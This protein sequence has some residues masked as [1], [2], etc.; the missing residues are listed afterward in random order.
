MK[1][2]KVHSFQSM[3]DIAVQEYGSPEGVIAIAVANNMSPTAE[4]I[5]GSNILVPKLDVETPQRRVLRDYKEQMIIPATGMIP[6][7]ILEF[8]EGDC[9]CGEFTDEFSFEFTSCDC[10]PND[11][12][13][14]N[15]FTEE[16][17]Q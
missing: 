7:D 3:I 4:L 9:D 13:F 6:D 11:F 5:A 15:D 1:K 14:N 17:S 10:D 12:G 8:L 16:F 2:I